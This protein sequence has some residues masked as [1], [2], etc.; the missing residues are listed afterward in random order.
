LA[1]FAQVGW[2]DLDNLVWFC[3]STNNFVPV[4]TLSHELAI[5]VTFNTAAYIVNCDYTGGTT[6]SVSISTAQIKGQSYP[7]AF[8]DQMVHVTGMEREFH[9]GLYE[10]KGLAIAHTNFK[11]QPRITLNAGSSGTLTLKMTSIKDPITEFYWAARLASD[12]QTDFGNN[13]NRF[14]SY[15]GF[16]FTGNAGEMIPFHPK[17][18]IDRRLREQY[19]SSIPTDNENLGF[20]SFSWIPED[21]VN[22]N[23]AVHFGNISDPTINLFIGTTLGDSDLYDALNGGGIWGAAGVTCVIDFWFNTK[24]WIHQVGGDIRLVFS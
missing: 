2:Y 1:N 21:H 24:N 14:L 12:V 11:Q 15:V 23:G 3:Y 7:L 13:P 9:V 19:H 10:G 8:V 4:L 6:P 17:E 20:F 16:S 18:Y 22:E 5:D